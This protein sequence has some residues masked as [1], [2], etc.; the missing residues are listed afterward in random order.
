[1]HQSLTTTWK[2]MTKRM[3]RLSARSMQRLMQKL[4]LM[5]STAVAGDAHAAT[6]DIDV[7]AAPAA[8]PD[9]A[10]LAADGDLAI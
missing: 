4:E 3:I 6:D 2:I 9:A 8:V 1:M 5:P 7:V 10:D